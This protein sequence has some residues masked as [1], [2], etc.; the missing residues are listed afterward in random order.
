MTYDVLA[1]KHPQG[2]YVATALRWP[3][4]VAEA[5][6]QT[7]ALDRIREAIAVLVAQGEVV[8]VEVP[9]PLAAIPAPY[10]ETFGM[11]RHDPTFDK[12]VAAVKAYRRKRNRS[13]RN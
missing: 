1:R 6:T 12:F 5:A 3:E 7:E 4:V 11:F 8:Q 9:L 10:T 13:S 2:G